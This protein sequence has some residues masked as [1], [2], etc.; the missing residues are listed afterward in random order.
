MFVAEAHRDKGKRYIV[1]ADEKLTRFWNGNQ[2]FALAVNSLDKQASF[3][4]TPRT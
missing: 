1:R 2:R 3:C 4:N